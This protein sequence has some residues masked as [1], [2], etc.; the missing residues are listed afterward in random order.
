LQRDFFI[1][2]KFNFFRF[3]FQEGLGVNWKKKNTLF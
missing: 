3:F 2:R 1:I